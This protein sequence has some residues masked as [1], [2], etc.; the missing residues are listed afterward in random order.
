MLDGFTDGVVIVEGDVAPPADGVAAPVA[1]FSGS[2]DCPAFDFFFL[3]GVA[4]Y[5]VFGVVA[6]ALA[7][8]P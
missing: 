8:D 5:P 4:L 3:D 1:G 6:P 7:D 2:A